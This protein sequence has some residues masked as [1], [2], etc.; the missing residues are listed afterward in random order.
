M[1]MTKI[2]LLGL[3]VSLVG[4]FEAPK[5]K[6]AFVCQLS[7]ECPDE[8]SCSAT[9]HRCHL[10]ENGV[11]ATCTDNLPTADGG[12]DAPVDANTNID[13]TTPT[14][15][16]MPDGMVTP[17]VTDH[18]GSISIE[19][20]SIQNDPELGH[21]LQVSISLTP[22]D[23][24]APIYEEIPGSP[25]GCKA[26]VY[27]LTMGQIP[28]S[29][30]DEGTVNITGAA[31]LT[32]PPCTFVAALGG[33]ACIDVGSTGAGMIS[34]TDDSALGGA[35]PP[36]TALVQVAGATF[37]GNDLGRYVSLTGGSAANTGSFPIVGNGMTADT[38]II[39]N[40]GAATQAAFSGTYTTVAGVGPAPA[41]GEPAL[42][43][44]DTLNV[45]ITPG[46]G[47]HFSFA[48]ANVMVGDAF[49]LDSTS[50]NAITNVP[51][52][53]S[54]ITLSC[55][56]GC[57]A[58]SAFGSLIVMQTTD[59]VIPPGAPAYYMPPPAAKV[60]LVRCTGVGT[61]TVTVPAAAMAAIQQAVPSRVRTTFFRVGYAPVAN[62]DSTNGI[63]I[64]A[65]HAIAGFTTNSL[66]CNMPS[67]CPGA[68]TECLTRTCTAHACG[69]SF[70]AMGTVT[71][72]QTMGD[73]QTQICDGMGAFSSIANNTDTPTDAFECT[74]DTCVAG[75]PTFTP[76]PSGTMCATGVCNGGTSCV[77]CVS[78]S[79]CPAA[80]DPNCA[81]ATCT[82]NMCGFNF[83]ASGTP[84]PAATQT[85]GN[86]H[87]MRCDGAG[88]GT[89]AVD[90]TDVPVDANQCTDNV[91]TAGVPS[92]P[93]SPTGLVCTMGGGTVCDGS[94]A[95]VQCNVPANCPGTDTE[96]AT[97]TCMTNTCGVSNASAG[98]ACTMGGTMCDGAG[99]CVP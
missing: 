22:L 19:D 63:N 87:E 1:S 79:G 73:C 8:Y 5:P 75:V 46:G 50:Q 99:N 7:T 52:D 85:P 42:A 49:T 83:V 65:G 57:G 69:G 25:L 51:I 34:V 81:T 74:N 2:V 68:D 88:T 78:A 17:P 84:T 77:Q 24:Q 21:G 16:A 39:G 43:D 37:D 44:S 95:C 14:P 56:T 80:A 60:G 13:G 28:P 11:P 67:D 38:I 64:I 94:G 91:C 41:P 59:N 92:N 98:T 55:A 97:R 12:P 26:W 23:P 9:D 90:D 53:G 35:I 10:L 71:A 40:P 86:C 18:E 89:N 48:P 70:T 33:Y 61:G 36:G 96:C 82:S 54:P 62:P 76:K 15:D 31:G 93:S 6:C 29:T 58:G 20:L 72:A 32:I 30:D 66:F 27:D 45:A 3:A 4:C 47:N